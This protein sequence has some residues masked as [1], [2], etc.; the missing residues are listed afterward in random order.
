V[1]TTP[2]VTQ[3]TLLE[4]TSEL[5]YGAFNWAKAGMGTLFKSYNPSL[6]IGSPKK[7][8]SLSL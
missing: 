4:T 2:P 7:S 5:V 1:Q 8:A 6:T 3:T